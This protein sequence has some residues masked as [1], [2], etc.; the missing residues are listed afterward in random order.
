MN[1]VLT[2]E[3]LSGLELVPGPVFKPMVPVGAPTS[4]ESLE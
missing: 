2:K 1:E 3:K 4:A